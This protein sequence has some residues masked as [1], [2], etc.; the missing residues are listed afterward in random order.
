MESEQPKR[1]RQPKA[2]LTEVGAMQKIE[3][4]LFS[5]TIPAQERIIAYFASAVR[6]RGGVYSTVPTN[7]L[8]G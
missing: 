4:V 3:A 8:N 7:D 1:T 2:P 6:E 5:L